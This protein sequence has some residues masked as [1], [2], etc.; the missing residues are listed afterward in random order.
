MPVKNEYLWGMPKP[1]PVHVRIPADL[2]PFIEREQKLSGNCSAG[3]VVRRI[4]A[5]A[6][7]SKPK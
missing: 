2:M 1:K 6:R 4:L 3:A 5:L 7:D